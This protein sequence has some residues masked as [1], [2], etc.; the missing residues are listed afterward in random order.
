MKLVKK[1]GKE[2][3]ANLMDGIKGKEQNANLMDGIK[4]S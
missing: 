1:K 4:L 3:N 2:Q